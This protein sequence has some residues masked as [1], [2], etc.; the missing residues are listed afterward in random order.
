MEPPEIEEMHELSI[1]CRGDSVNYVLKSTGAG[2][3]TAERNW[4]SKFTRILGMYSQ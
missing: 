1:K 3:Y 4:S 2:D